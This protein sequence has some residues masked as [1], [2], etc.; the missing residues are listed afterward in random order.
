MRIVVL[1]GKEQF[2]LAEYARRLAEA[3]RE[4]HGSIDEFEFDGDS[5]EPA[6]LFDELRS[7]ALL[8]RHKLVTLDRADGFLTPA[9]EAE[10]G[11]SITKKSKENPRRRALE[12]YA[13]SPMES[14]TLLMRAETWRPGN[15]DAI[16]ARAGGVIV[17][18][19]SPSDEKAMRWCVERCARRYDATLSDDA[20]TRLV[21]RIGPDLARLDVELAKLATFIGSGGIIDSAAVERLVA[22]SRQEKAWMIQ[23]AVMTGSAATAMTRLRELLE[24][25]RQDEVPITWSIGDVCRKLHAASRLLQ[26]GCS[27]ADLTRPPLK[28]WGSTTPAITETARRVAPDRLARLFGQA[29]LTDLRNKSGWGEAQRN[30]EGLTVLVTDVVGG[31]PRQAGRA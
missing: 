20:A 19:D 10:D 31:A 17:H 26:A 12:R 6:A 27:P 29:V 30:L 25:S 2:L 4:R 24:V 3:L 23:E 21:M 9:S 15:L 18:C 22:P 13:E 1:H 28:L 7:Y 16:I 11:D 14:A 5:V 8:S